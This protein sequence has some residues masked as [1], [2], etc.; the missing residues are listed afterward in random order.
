ML[1]NISTIRDAVAANHTLWWV[2]HTFGNTSPK[3]NNKNVTAPT[4]M[5]NSAQKLRWK[6]PIQSSSKILEIRMM[7]MFTKL[8]VISIAASKVFGC[9]SKLTMRRYEGCC[10]VLRTLISFKVSEK[11]ATSEPA[12]R[13]DKLKSITTRKRSTP[14]AAGVITRKEK[15]KL[16][17][18]MTEW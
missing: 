3:S 16:L 13:K 12:I 17:R 1:L 6:L 9:S 18:S 4:L 5:R 10:F 15:G 2:A 7:P 8:L 11:K 14:V